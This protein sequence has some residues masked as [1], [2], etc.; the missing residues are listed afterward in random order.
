MTASAQPSVSEVFQARF[1]SGKPGIDAWFA[2]LIHPDG[3][4]IWLRYSRLV[5]RGS[6]DGTP[7]GAIWATLF[8]ANDPTKYVSAV[9]E[10]PVGPDVLT[11]DRLRGSVGT[12]AGELSWDLEI[13]GDAGVHNPVPPW[14]ARLPV[15][16]SNVNL[17]HRA[18]ATGTVTLDGETMGFDGAR[19]IF[20]HLWGTRH[21]AE[22]YWVFVPRFDDDPE[23]WSL[24]AVAAR[25]DRTSP[26]LVWGVLGGPNGVRSSGGLWRMLRGGCAVNYPDVRLDVRGSRFR[27]SVAATLNSDQAAAFRY[28]DPRG[29]S[30]HVE[31]SDVSSAE[32]T[33][34]VD[35]RTRTLRSA[36]GAAVE[37]H[38]VAPWR[39][40]PYLDPYADSFPSS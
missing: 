39:D 7:L 25:T 31:Q 38:R 2:V 28:R 37:V 34:T 8:D 14:L 40:V 9:A 1:A 33:I 5:P 27:A 35:G 4:S 3:R 23:E 22:I 18:R 11:A 10:L 19:G 21:P 6:T 12:S 17:E 30:H 26:L 15:G 13:T 24:E 20:S 32:V 36:H 29:R 16:T